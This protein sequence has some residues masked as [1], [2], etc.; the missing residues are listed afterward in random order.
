M[1][2]AVSIFF[3]FCLSLTALAQESVFPDSSNQ[4]VVVLSADWDCPAGEMYRFER[5][6]TSRPWVPVGSAVPVN[7]GRTGMAWGRSPLMDGS[8]KSKSSNPQEKVEGDGRS[9]AGLFPLLK[10]FGHPSAPAGYKDANLE[11]LTVT[12]EQCVDDSES[13]YYNQI[14]SPRKVGGDTWNSAEKMNI[15]LYQ[16]GLVVGHN[17]PKASPRMGSCIFFHLQRAAGVSTAGCT[18]MNRASLEELVLWL[19]R[20]QNPVLLQLPLGVYTKLGSSVPRLV[21]D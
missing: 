17:C 1:R 21:K 16:L 13:D 8:L 3:I 5:A 11:F 15:D 18:S 20:E 14:V 7:L 6:S 9:P 12:D 10:A 2:I 19:K 4:L